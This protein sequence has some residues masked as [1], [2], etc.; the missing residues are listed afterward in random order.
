M[1]AI[2]SN[3]ATVNNDVSRDMVKIM[4][5]ESKMQPNYVVL[6][7]AA[8][9]AFAANSVLCRMSL[10]NNLI[11]ATSFTAIRIV[12][13]AIC[14]V[15]ISMMRNTEWR[16]AKPNWLPILS[17]FTY[18]ACFSFAYQSLSTGTGALLLFGFV[19]LT[20]IAA[21]L[22]TGER[23]SGW[24]WFGLS[25]AIGGMIYLV[26]PGLE[27]PD[28]FNSI[29]M[30]IA[31]MAWGAYSLFGMGQGD[32]TSATA[33]NFLYA[34]PLAIL[35]CIFRNDDLFLTYHGTLLAAISGAVTSGVGYAIWYKALKGITASTASIVQL[36]VP[37]LATLG[38]VALLSEP[39]NLR[40]AVSIALTLSGIA[41]V[42]IHRSARR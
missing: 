31:G 4:L 16:P 22:F 21:A 3:P 23:L 14:L 39:L 12:S 9:A 26:L 34:I 2:V 42:I 20:M 13:G 41:I 7:V 8:M 35:W 32:A 11:D 30:A 25:V 40:I 15:V 24:S 10:G 36:S 19:Q 29:L 37:A 17:L 1:P 5:K 28:P 27:A 33:N 6:T 38:G 18:M